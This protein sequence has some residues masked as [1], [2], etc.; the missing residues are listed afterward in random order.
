MG[1]MAED[2]RTMAP[3]TCS[4]PKIWGRRMAWADQ[5][6]TSLGN[7]IRPHLAATSGKMRS[8]FWD[9][10]LLRD[11]IPFKTL[12]SVLILWLYFLAYEDERLNTDLCNGLYLETNR[13]GIIEGPSLPV[14]HNMH[15]DYNR[16]MPLICVCGGGGQ[17]PDFFFLHVPKSLNSCE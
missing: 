7:I 6:E 10:L 2:Y 8:A 1:N 3:G 5:S 11:N 12:Y 17:L 13:D 9:G 15:Y 16:N 14:H 4:F